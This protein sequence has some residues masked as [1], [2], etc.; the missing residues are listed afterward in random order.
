RRLVFRV[1]HAADALG[2]LPRSFIEKDPMYASAFLANMASLGMP[3][4]Y[5]HLYEYGT[6]SVFGSVGRPV[7]DPGSPTSGPGRRRSTTIKGTCDERVDDGLA[8][9]FALRYLK[10]AMEDPARVD[11]VVEPVPSGAAVVE[12]GTE[13]AGAPQERV[14]P[15][16]EPSAR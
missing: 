13:P 14:Q 3:A 16:Q 7:T 12:S 1:L 8:A 6:V 5:H 4:V 10:Q 9:W 2:L 11:L 15:E